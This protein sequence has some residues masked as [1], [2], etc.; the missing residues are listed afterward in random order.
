MLPQKWLN[1]PKDTTAGMD[2]TTLPIWAKGLASIAATV[3]LVGCA[4]APAVDYTPPEASGLVGVSPYPG[5]GDVCQI[6]GENDLTAEYLDHTQT[7]FGC[8]T[9]ETGAIADR[10]AEGAVELETI[11]AWTLYTISNE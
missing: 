11:G 10:L 7:L 9:H 1:G 8:P 4:T 2:M 6:I 3:F 5:A